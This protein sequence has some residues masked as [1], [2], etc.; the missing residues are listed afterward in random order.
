MAALLRRL[1]NVGLS[2]KFLPIN[3]CQGVSSYPTFLK[4]YLINFSEVMALFIFTQNVGETE[5]EVIELGA[6]QGC[7]YTK[8]GAIDN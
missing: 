6:G 1:A 2:S 8:L 7:S 4:R 5:L 3:T